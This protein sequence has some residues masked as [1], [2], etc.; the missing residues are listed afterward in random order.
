M[1]TS[2]V[3]SSVDEERQQPKSFDI[4]T[5]ILLFPGSVIIYR[6]FRQA[7]LRDVRNITVAEFKAAAESLQPQFGS[8]A[9]IRL[10]RQ[11]KDTVIF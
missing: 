2:L 4:T 3:S 9:C 6:G 7:A 8:V 11:S 10:R 5:A 1:I